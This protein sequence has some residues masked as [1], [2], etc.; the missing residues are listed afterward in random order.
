M[1]FAERGGCRIHWQESG[2]GSPLLL[3]MG[4][5]YSS[6]LWYPAWPALTERHRVIRFDNRGTGRSTATRAASISDMANDALAVLDAAGVERAHVYGIS[7]GGVVAQQLAIEA[8]GRVRSLVLGCTGILT[9]DKP[10]AP[11]WW[12]IRFLLPKST[13]VAKTP[14]GPVC[15]PANITI[16]QEVLRR[17]VAKRRALIA[18]QDALRNYAVTHEAIAALTMPALVLHGTADPVV[19]LE[20]GRELAATLPDS[21]LVIYEGAGHNYVVEMCDRA[22]DDVLAFLS[23][24]ESSVSA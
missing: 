10:R 1:S 24:V 5:V 16:N 7:L 6:E 3:I 19:P 8:P 12:D 20:W 17:D 22:S 23:T 13:R 21:Q 2:E 9:T 11:K 4:A 18:Q 15:P 14:Y